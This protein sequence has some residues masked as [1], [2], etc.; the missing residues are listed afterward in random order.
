M[1]LFATLLALLATSNAAPTIDKRLNACG[2]SSFYADSSDPAYYRDCEE[3]V[4]L[5]SYTLS[6]N[7]PGFPYNGNSWTTVIA[8]G[9]CAF[10]I[11]SI[12]G[13]S[14]SIGNEDVYDLVRDTLRDSRRGDGVG[15]K[16][17]MQCN[18]VDV[19]WKVGRASG[20]GSTI[21][22]G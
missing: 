21:T 18:G 13:W 5:L 3:I 19:E 6:S 20:G 4:S 12:R 14:S 1:R 9:T 8:E 22:I 16:G 15:A 11:R 10:S 2:I 7:F 17:S